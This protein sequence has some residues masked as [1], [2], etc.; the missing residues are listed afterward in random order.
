MN[1][2]PYEAG[3]KKLA[4]FLRDLR[5]ILTAREGG[6]RWADQV[7]PLTTFRYLA[8]TAPH[9]VR[10]E[11]SSPPLAV[12]CLAAKDRTTRAVESGA[13]VTWTWADGSIAVSAIDVAEAAHEYEVTLGLLMG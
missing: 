6:L 9:S 7:A 5:Q 12:L 11:A 4:A 10:V 3:E 1:L 13:R 8:A 2:R